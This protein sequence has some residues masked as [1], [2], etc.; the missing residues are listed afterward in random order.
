MSAFTGIRHF[1]RIRVACKRSGVAKFG[2]TGI[3]IIPRIGQTIAYGH[4]R[5]GRKFSLFYSDILRLLGYD[6]LGSLADGHRFG[7]CGLA[8]LIGDLAVKPSAVTVIVHLNRIGIPGKAIRFAESTAVFI[9]KIPFVLQPLTA[10]TYR[11]G[12]FLPFRHPHALGLL[13]DLHSGNLIQRYGI[14]DNGVA[15]A[16]RNLTVDPSAVTGIVHLYTVGLA[17]KRV[18]LV[19]GTATLFSKVPVVLQII[20][21]GVNRNLCGFTAKY[22]HILHNGG[23]AVVPLIDITGAG[24]V[25]T[26]CDCVAAVRVGVS[27]LGAVDGD[28]PDI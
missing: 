6:Q 1:Y 11:Y 5:C 25:N 3:L 19:E 4:Y 13:K 18:S 23:L 10:G 8:V 24:I 7:G 22:G 15:V 14:T 12:C 26:I 2:I 21:G 28:R 27:R 17:G 16:V 9:R 20:T